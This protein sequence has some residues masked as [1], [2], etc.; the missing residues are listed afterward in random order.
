MRKKFAGLFTFLVMLV[1]FCQAASAEK[2]EFKDESYN[3]HNIKNIAVY[4]LDFSQAPIGNDIMEKSLNASYH[5]RAT[6]EKLP[7]VNSESIIRKMS[8]ALGQDLDILA[9]NDWEAFN[10]V[11]DENLPNYIDAYVNASVLQYETKSI[12]HPEYTTWET[13]KEKSYVHDSKGNRIEVEDEVLVPVTHPAY[14]SSI[15]LEKVEF[16]VHD[17]KTG[18]EVYSFQEWRD[19]E[20]DDGVNMFGRICSSFFK[21]FGN[22]IK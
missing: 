8:L 1:L 18:R 13:R 6:Q 21:S 19:R 12:Y 2:I 16:H 4:D 11:Y 15:I 3:F 5:K 17:A 20:D 7:V 14:Y 22:L 10:K 9:K